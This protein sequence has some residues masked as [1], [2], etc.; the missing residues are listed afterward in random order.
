MIKT[1]YFVNNQKWKLSIKC[2]YI[3]NHRKH[4]KM[5]RSIGIGALQKEKQRRELFERKGSSLAKEELEKLTSQMGEFRTN[6]EKFALKHK[7]DIK[8]NAEF[9]RQ[10]QEMCAVAGVDPLKTSSNFWVKL[11]GV[12]DFYYELAIQI[13]EIFLSTGHKNGGIM[14]IEE[15]LERV[16]ASRGV[17]N[18][19]TDSVTS[20]DILVAL[21]KLRLLNSNLKEI[22]SNGSYIIHSIPSELN[23]DHVDIAQVAHS[24]GGYFSF[25][26][27]RSK[28]PNWSD[29]RT[30]KSIDELIMEGIVWVDNQGQDGGTLYWFSGLK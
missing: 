22:P 4:F 9:R 11:L 17:T 15:L 1:D 10:F 13:A 19:K 28:F 30:Q 25:Q 3:Q 20:S 5:R 16:K 24:L 27:L 12:G 23:P 7:R 21:K 2:I 26:I 8:K 18:Q 29:E 6:L 14:T